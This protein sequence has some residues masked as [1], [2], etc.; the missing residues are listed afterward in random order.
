MSY[1]GQSARRINP[2]A[3][4]PTAPLGGVIRFGARLYLAQTQ[5]GLEGVAW[6]EIAF[7]CGASG[8]ARELARRTIGDRAG[9]TIFHAERIDSLRALRSVEDL[10]ALVGYRRFAPVNPDAPA[11]PGAA[12]ER[13]R[14]AVHDAR[15]IDEALETRARF[16]PGGRAGRR[17]QFRVVARMAGDHEFRRVDFRRAVENA[18][19]ERGDHVWRLAGDEADADV[20]FWATM[21][22]GEF[23]LAL[24]LSD[25]RM[26]HR[27][28]KAA[29]LPGSL[30]PAVAAA[31]AWL[32]D[33]AEHDVTLDPFCGAGTVLVERAHLGRYAK[34][35]GGDSDPAALAAARENIGP[36]HQPLELHEWNATALPLARA[37]VT[38]VV[39]NLPWGRRHGSHEKNLTLY[40]RA[41]AELRRVAAPGATFV[42]LTADSRLM[43][44]A[45]RRERMRP[46]RI[47]R[48]AILGAPATI[49]VMRNS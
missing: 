12:L 38:K 30:R 8:P 40:P 9:A 23:L 44:Q 6:S 41:L 2:P 1:R 13:V 24:R 33:P 32:S 15:Y 4:R 45:I 37:C 49:Y 26:R 35:I 46:E 16:T 29:H 22:P 48:V 39:T 36:R 5:P 43:D 14:A 28:Y 7:R 11:R 47:F 27:E 17:I 10:F 25:E 42:I 31:M 3:R 19:V 20:E 21:L 18:M 34:L